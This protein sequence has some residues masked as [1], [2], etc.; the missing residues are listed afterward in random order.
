M[1]SLGVRMSLPTAAVKHR[2]A[3]QERS[4]TALLLIAAAWSRMRDDLDSSWFEVGPQILLLVRAAQLGAARDAAA[5]VPFALAEQ[6]APAAAMAAVNPVGFVGAWPL[7]DG[8]LGDLSDLLYGAVVRARAARVDSFPARLDAG[9]AWLDTVVKTQLS[10]ASRQSTGA[11]IA[12][13]DR[14]GFVRVVGVPCC[15]RCAVLAGRFYKFSSG[16]KRHPRC[17]CQNVPTTQS[18]YA[19]VA[20]EIGPDDV[21]DL[22]IAQRKAIGDGADF[23][24]VINSHRHGARS[25]DGMTTTS[26]IK[27]RGARGVRP[28]PEAIYKGSTS[29]EQAVDLLRKYGYLL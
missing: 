22:T 27:L 5:Y 6:G 7:E 11:A 28:T 26:A 16:F 1:I 21:R 8:H 25:A 2:A 19:Q 12:A 23:N 24:Q 13:T 3:Q 17:D 9:R 4:A 20:P 29:R 10:D 14:A 15:Q 18:R